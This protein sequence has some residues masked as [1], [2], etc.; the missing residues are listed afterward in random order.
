MEL[1][2]EALQRRAPLWE[3]LADFWLDTELADWQYEHIARVIAASTYSPEEV[4][5]IHDF[6]VAPVVWSNLLCVAGVWSGF[7]GAWLCAECRRHARRRKSAVHRLLCRVRLA[8]FRRHLEGCWSE[9]EARVARLS[10]TRG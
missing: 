9:V 1:T 8:C 5:A 7:D 2:A 4:R 10:A 6:E 3:A